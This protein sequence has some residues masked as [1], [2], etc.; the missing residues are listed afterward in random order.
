MK[1]I[2]TQQNCKNFLYEPRKMLLFHREKGSGIEYP[3]SISLVQLHQK[4]QARHMPLVEQ[5]Q[6]LAPIA[7]ET[8]KKT[9][10]RVAIM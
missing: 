9:I 3:D 1:R 7:E 8:D 6:L 10:H 5:H 4:Y 2:A